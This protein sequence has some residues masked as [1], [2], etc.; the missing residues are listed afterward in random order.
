MAASA[1]EVEPE[2]VAELVSSGEA[3]VIDVRTDTEYEAGRIRGAEHVPFEEL[4]A[5]AQTLDKSRPVLFYCQSGSRSAVAAEAFAA[6]GWQ[7]HTMTGG[8]A[9]WAER[10]LPLDPEGGRVKPPSGLPGP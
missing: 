1:Q 5:R 4:T 3:Q 7:A 9:E 6:S 8:L 2:R 10:G